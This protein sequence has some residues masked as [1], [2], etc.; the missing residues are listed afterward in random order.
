MNRIWTFLFDARVLGVIGLA[1]LAAFLFLG[2]EA[3]KLGLVWAAVAL[4]AGLLVWGCVWGVRKWRARRAAKALEQGIDQQAATAADAAP[5][6]KRA[7]ISLLRGRLT[8]AV[9]TIKKSK[10]GERTGSA[11]LYELPWYLVIGNPAAG[12]ST[13]IVQSGL[14]FPFADDVGQIVQGIGGTRNCDWFFTSDGILLDTAGRYSVHEE[15]RKEWLGFLGL[16][17]RYRPKAPINGIIIAASVAELANSRPEQAITL[18]KNLRQRVQELTENLEVFAPVYVLFTK[19][20]LV[21]GFAEFFADSEPAERNRVWGAT[22]PYERRVAHTRGASASGSQPAFKDDKRRAGSAG[23]IDLLGLFDQRFDELADGLKEMS[24]ARMGIQRGQ[25]LP[26]GVLTFPLEFAGL[27]PALRS[28]VA[29]LFEDNAFQFQPVFRGFYFTSAVQEASSASRASERISQQFA[30]S[31]SPGERAAPVAQPAQGFFLRELFAKVIFAD[32]ELVRQHASRQKLRTRN[33]AFGIGVTVLAVALGGW[34]WSWLGN[35]QLAGS[36]MA[37][38]DKA[39]KLQAD[40]PDL[41]SRMEALELLQDRIEQLQRWRE[42]RPLGVSLGLY[43]GEQLERRL[44]EE[45]F[46]GIRLVMLQPV[47]QTIEG[48]LAE[49]NRDPTRLKPM[50]RAPDSGAAR[51]E[52]RAEAS[53][54]A[55]PVRS[56]ARF[57]DASPE[58]SADA[59]N[60]LKTYLMLADRDRLEASHLTDQITRFWRGWLDDNR[61]TMPRELLMRSAERLISFTTSNLS[62]PAFPLQSNQLALVDST[63]QN[64]RDVAR[65]LR[66]VERV[67]ADVKTRAATRFPP[68]TVA[69]LVTEADKGVLAGSHA[70]PGPFTRQAW[71]GYIEK[72]FKD[73]ATS[74][75]QSTDWVLKVASG[76][77]LTLEGSPEQIRKQLTELY[78]TEYVAE[79]RKFVQ[80]VAIADFATFELATERMNRLGDLQNSPI[81]GLLQVLFDQTSWDNPSLL[82][83]RL[84]STQKGALDWFKQTIL[85]Q[86]PSKVEVNVNLS[87]GQAQ[88]PLGPIGREFAPLAR[89]MMSRDNTPAPVTEYLQALGKVRTRLNLI[90]TQ[91]DPGPGARALM[92]Q[93]LE[94][95]NSELGEALRL[96]DERMLV[97][98]TPTAKEALRPLL[99]RPLTQAMAALVPATETEL[100][101]QWSAQVYEPFQRTLAAKYPF[102]TASRVEA[103]PADVSKLLGP[104]GAVAKFGTEALAPLVNN[105]GNL[106]QSRTWGDVGVRLKPEFAAGYPLW[107]SLIELGGGGSNAGSGSA[108][109]SGSAGAAG[110]GAEVANQTV[111]EV[112]PL[113]AP[114]LTEYSL[115]IDGQ[116]LR[117]RNTAAQWTRMVWPNPGG[118]A[119][120]RL[121]GVTL[122][123]QAVEFVIEPGLSGLDRLFA[124]AKIE[125]RGSNGHEMSWVKG[126]SRVAIQLR[127]I[128]SPG[129]M[130]RA[131]GSGSGSG[132]SGGSSA[133]A[134]PQT[135]LAALRGLKLP[136]TVAGGDATPAPPTTGP[137]PGAQTSAASAPSVTNASNPRQGAGTNPNTNSSAGARP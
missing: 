29:T 39:T 107:V 2:A 70:V 90:K 82:N 73:A 23:R 123:G 137:A 100:N 27:K 3:L 59:Y 97:G 26:P 56:A 101:R 86:A 10:L 99:V 7:E 40:R 60:A 32:R 114:G 17:K 103:T 81:R 108:G 33:V 105:R 43:Q 11:A 22:L 117:H 106:I 21:A 80:G 18:A 135:G 89:I 8:E 34:S 38:L 102:D 126:N 19:A 111:F 53:T 16:L 79:W 48:Y 20:D 124:A 4:G 54:T 9:K 119:G 64:L 104:G 42:D 130:A 68:I 91:G 66:G 41:A 31:A 55:T 5:A 13:A 113:G 46:A 92:A 131:T 67:Y 6:A 110:G 44:R 74:D 72:A 51:A 129:E 83:E 25:A 45:Y 87:A 61:G 57:I 133:G 85:R 132:S 88:I 112:M 36:V 98:M 84:A 58:D 127:K 78:K 118:V 12:K 35:R 93:T 24:V 15:D 50:L 37:D 77:D 14:N 94:G 75:S 116:V 63:R 128:T 71:D 95:G 120:V 134:A 109:S 47:A 69:G 125:P 76:S 52:T 136:A 1:A 62:D 96:V 30:L 49:V 28:F 122:D 115:V 121:T 65:G